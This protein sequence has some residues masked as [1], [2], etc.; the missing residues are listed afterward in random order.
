[1][2]SNIGYNYYKKLLNHF[3][4]QLNKKFK[5]SLI[6]VVLYGSVA[7]GNAK[8]NSDIDLLL[9]INKPPS[10]YHRRIEK[11]MEV[12][13]LLEKSEEYKKL[14]KRDGIEPYFNYIIFSKEEALENHYIFLDM[15]EDAKILFDKNN[16]FTK[17][18]KEI[19]KRLIELGSEKVYLEDGTWYWDLKPDLKL[20]EVF[21]L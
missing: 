4:Y 18:L 2:K 12:E 5:E 17:R 11:V 13:H 21:S 6:S 14:K 8:E 3:L 19:K 15:I 9:I 1:M 20:G 16:F 10:N 7:R